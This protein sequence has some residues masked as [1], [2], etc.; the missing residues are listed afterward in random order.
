MGLADVVSP[1]VTMWGKNKKCKK[2]KWKS[3]QLKGMEKYRF[4]KSKKKAI[5][6]CKRSGKW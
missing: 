3:S 2:M 6:K 5:V 1:P 4:M